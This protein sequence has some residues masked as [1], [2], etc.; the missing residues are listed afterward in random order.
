MHVSTSQGLPGTR[1]DLSSGSIR[2][3][4]QI[5]DAMQ[6]LMPRKPASTRVLGKCQER[7]KSNFK[8]RG[9]GH[10]ETLPG[11]WRGPQLSS[12]GDPVAKD[13][14]LLVHY[15][16]GS[17]PRTPMCDHRKGVLLFI[18]QETFASRVGWGMG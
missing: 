17:V 2:P 11:T 6:S 12:T 9:R 13:V 4:A 16:L 5:K 15:L 18:H 8:G 1:T 14:S 3:E 10:P 7:W